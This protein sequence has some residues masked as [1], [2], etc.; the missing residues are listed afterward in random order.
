M[1]L[2]TSSSG[3]RCR[4]SGCGSPRRSSTGPTRCRP[5]ASCSASPSSS[6]RSSAAWRYSSGIDRVW[7]LARRAAGHDQRDGVLGRVF[8]TTAVV[9]AVGFTVWLVFIGGLGLVG[10]C[11]ADVPSPTAVRGHDRRSRSPTQLRA[12]AA[13]RRR[14]ALARVEPLDLSAH[15]VAR[16]TRPRRSSTRSPTRLASACTATPT[17]TR[18]ALRS[19]LAHRHAVPEGAS[20]SATAAA[21]LLGAAAQALLEPGD[22]LV[23]P[24]PSYGLYPV[25]AHRARGRAVPVAG[26][27]ADAVL[28]A[29][30][31]RTR[32]VALCNPNDPTG[33]LVGAGRAPRAARGAARA[34]RRPPRRGAARLRRRRGPRRGA[35]TARRPPAAARLP[36]VLEGVGPGGA[37]RRATRSEV[38]APSRCSSASSPSSGSTSS[39]RPARSRRCGHAAP[40][41]AG[42]VGAVARRARAPHRRAARARPRSRAQPGQRPLA[43]RAGARGRRARAPPR[44]PRRHRRPG[45]PARRRRPRARRRPRPAGGRPPPRGARARAAGLLADDAP[46]RGRG[47]NHQ[48]SSD[49]LWRSSVPV[50]CSRI[51]RQ[52][53]VFSCSSRR[54]SA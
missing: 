22:E 28:R 26:F 10:R 43:R 27:G 11:R 6:P 46:P 36:D 3:A 49:A 30:N 31:E 38:R 29:V 50:V 51:L 1:I 44:A 18:S 52:A 33:E 13:E 47:I 21:Q 19:E 5:R 42:R 40:V 7:I 4:R 35:R 17:A 48:A 20:S 12:Q 8:A 32:L 14:R 41:V 25:M 54:R 15:D 45:R 2:V 53:R 34:R 23:T 39:R 9:G 16:A 24:W 37:A